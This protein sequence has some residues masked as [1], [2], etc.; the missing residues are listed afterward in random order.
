MSLSFLD[1]YGEV[2]LRIKMLKYLKF[3]FPMEL[4]DSCVLE[5]CLRI[6]HGK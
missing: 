1:S 2:Q 5:F 6:W 4:F 3:K